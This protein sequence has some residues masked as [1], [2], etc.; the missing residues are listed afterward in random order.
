[1]DETT[2]TTT[3]ETAPAPVGR[4]CRMK[5]NEAWP[6]EITYLIRGYLRARGEKL[7]PCPACGKKTRKRWTMLCPFRAFTLGQ[8][9]VEPAGTFEPLTLVCDEHPINPTDEIMKAL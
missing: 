2:T 7:P 4:F 5:P 3:T 1:M 8:F 6:P 9:V